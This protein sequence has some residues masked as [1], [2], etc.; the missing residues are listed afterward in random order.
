MQKTEEVDAPKDWWEDEGVF[1]PI[2]TYTLQK[3]EYLDQKSATRPAPYAPERL[4]TCQKANRDRLNS[5]E[6]DEE[7][8]WYNPEDHKETTYFNFVNKNREA[9]K[10]ND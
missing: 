6:T 8:E 2:S 1:Y 5:E 10:A 9:Y 4:E 7:F 3:N